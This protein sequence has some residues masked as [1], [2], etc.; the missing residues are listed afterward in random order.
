[1]L[2]LARETD[3][4]AV[5]ALS[6]Q[7]HQQRVSWRPDLYVACQE[8][9]PREKF[10]EDIRQRM[11]YLVRM[12]QVVAGYVV[13]SMQKKDGPGMISRKVMCLEAICVEESIRGHGLGKEMMA[14]VRA[15]ARAFGCKEISLRV[16]AENDPAVGFYQKCGFRI[17][18]INMD[19][20]L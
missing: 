2:E 15:L 5:K 12:E 8:P 4:D 6:L 20:K 1:M 11:V 17:R 9:Y 7:M 19:M 13:L 10:L 16:H 3:W 18:T 14:D